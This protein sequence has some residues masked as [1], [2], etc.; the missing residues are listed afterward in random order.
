M[1]ETNSNAE[2]PPY[3][4]DSTLPATLCFKLLELANWVDDQAEWAND[5]LKQMGIPE[6]DLIGSDFFTIKN[7]VDKKEESELYDAFVNNVS[8]KS[9]AC[10]W[11]ALRRVRMRFDEIQ[12]VFEDDWEA[13]ARVFKHATLI[14]MASMLIIV[15]F[16]DSEKR[17]AKEKEWEEARNEKFAALFIHQLNGKFKKQFEGSVDDSQPWPDE[18]SNPPEE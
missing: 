18:W 8:V 7:S 15:A 13:P 16:L 12:R 9:M 1:Y 3:A 10:S 14:K 6:E 17:E 5:N 4:G 11:D 2:K